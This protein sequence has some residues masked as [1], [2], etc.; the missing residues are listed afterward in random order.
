M[1]S[2]Q[3]IAA[4][5]DTLVEDGVDAHQALE[6]SGLQEPD[7][8]SVDTK[9]SYDQ[10]AIVFRNALRLARHP[11]LAMRAGRRMHITS[12]GM[13]GYAL[14]SSRVCS[15]WLDFS[16]RYVRVIGPLA[17]MRYDAERAPG[18]CRYEPLLCTDPQDALYRFALDFSYAAHLTL[19]QDLWGQAFQFTEVL[20]T[21]PRPADAGLCSELLGCAIRYGQATSEVR[22]DPAWVDRSPALHDPITH[23]MARQMC[24]QFLEELP[25]SGGTAAAVRK[26]LFEQMPWRFPNLEAM[27]RELQLEPRTLRRRLEAQGTT[28]REVLADVR[29]T[30]AENYLRRTKMTTEDIANR[31]GYSEAANFRHAFVRWTGKTPQEFRV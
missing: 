7:L 1:Y 14:L 16:T 9:V 26:A 31:L 23:A 30:L 20:V 5:V 28:Y 21:Y 4:V 3:R 18:A 6:G 29:R 19:G 17:D 11:A 10:V 15:E 8:R 27:A 12:Y 25:Q 24:Q 22:F 2:P 13:Y